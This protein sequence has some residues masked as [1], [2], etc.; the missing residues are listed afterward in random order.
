MP[1]DPSMLQGLYAISHK[2]TESSD[3][4]LK[5][6]DE[7]RH[8]GKEALQT[9]E[10]MAEMQR[11]IDDLRRDCHRTFLSNADKIGFSTFHGLIDLLEW[12][13]NLSTAYKESADAVM[14]LAPHL[15][16]RRCAT[17]SARR[18]RRFRCTVTLSPAA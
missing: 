4:F 10:K 11:E 6:V 15:N 12:L 2:L 1:A 18:L 7:I 16:A 3:L 8:R 13:G 5:A 9:A 14:M 17:L